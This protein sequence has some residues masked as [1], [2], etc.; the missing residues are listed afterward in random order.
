M[1][2][3]L[4]GV[5]AFLARV[6]WQVWVAI[7]LAIAVWRGIAWHK[8]AVTDAARAG[9]KAGYKMASDEF[10][11]RFRVIA[12]KADATAAMIRKA[13]D[14]KA[15]TISADADALRMRGPGAAR[16][17]NPPRAPAPGRSDAPGGGADAPAAG[18]LGSDWAAVPWQWLVAGAEICDLNR[19]EV[20]AWREWHNRL[21]AS[22]GA[23]A[24]PS[25]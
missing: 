22:A 14:E 23:P 11:E 6:P 17:T 16:C 19:N 4:L 1:T 18:V 10:A 25:K 8:D 12:I 5:R 9:V 7:A 15:H 13:T 20:V 2:A 21:T 24:R 3:F